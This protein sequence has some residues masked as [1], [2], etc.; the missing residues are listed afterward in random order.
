MTF[1]KNAD[2]VKASSHSDHLDS[3]TGDVSKLWNCDKDF[4]SCWH[5]YSL[6]FLY[7]IQT[8]LLALTE[9]VLENLQL[10]LMFHRFSP[11]QSYWFGMTKGGGEINL[12]A[13]PNGWIYWYQLKEFGSC[14]YFRV[15]ICHLHHVLNVGYGVTCSPESE[16][17][18]KKK[19]ALYINE[20]RMY[21]FMTDWHT[22]LTESCL[23]YCRNETLR[24]SISLGGTFICSIW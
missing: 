5:C 19:A 3:L 22:S 8:T 17:E 21:L 10:L 15:S 23:V 18:W 9:N 7:I 2:S 12:S 16:T 1:L 4:P 14:V 20:W 24:R 13:G 6:P 11:Q